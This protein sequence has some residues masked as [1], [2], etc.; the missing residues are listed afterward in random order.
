[1]SGFGFLMLFFEVSI[2]DLALLGV[3]A[4]FS[5]FEEL[6]L[7]AFSLGA[8]GECMLRPS[9]SRR[10]AAIFSFKSMAF[11]QKSKSNSLIS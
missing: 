1:M 9:L 10:L 6:W 5:M 4:G 11:S 3:F 2:F 8:W 7:D